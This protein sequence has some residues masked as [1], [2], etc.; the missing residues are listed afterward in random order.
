MS[1]TN[2]SMK[3]NVWDQGTD[4]FRYL[5]LADNFTKI[6]EHDHTTGKGVQISTDGIANAAVTEGK[7]ANASIT[8]D[9]VAA[10]ILPTYET[11]LPVGVDGKEI[12]Y[13]AN[14]ANSI[15]WHLR[16]TTASSKNRWEFV[17]G[18]PLSFF[19][20]ATGSGNL[21]P[22]DGTG[23]STDTWTKLT[24]SLTAGGEILSIPQNGKYKVDISVI[25][26]AGGSSSADGSENNVH[27]GL[28]RANNSPTNALN[29]D[30]YSVALVSDP[31]AS[32]IASLIQAAAYTSYNA[33]FVKGN[34]AG[35]NGDITAWFKT[36]RLTSNASFKNVSV[37]F[38]PIYI[39]A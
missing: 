35:N 29:V 36:N 6:A 37:S 2:N 4:V 14:S 25:L 39:T 9:K 8:R 31:P 38:T 33:V 10:N 18:A 28:G 32:T 21:T 13:V 20:I 23:V 22:Y 3:L 15:V 30:L 12:Y 11:T 7:I 19:D 16:Y 17:G 34:G 1:N 26:N 5:E 27:F 24:Y